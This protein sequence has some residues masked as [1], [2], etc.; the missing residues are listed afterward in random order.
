MD[1]S[2]LIVSGLLKVTFVDDVFSV[3]ALPFN[4]RVGK[5]NSVLLEKLDA[6]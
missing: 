2:E 1:S 6:L 4:S 3:S 5:V